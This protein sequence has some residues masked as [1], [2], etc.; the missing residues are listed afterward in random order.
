MVPILQQCR[1]I[2]I[3]PVFWTSFPLVVVLPPCMIIDSCEPYMIIITIIVVE[4]GVV[5]EVHMYMFESS[6]VLPCILT[7]VDVMMYIYIIMKWT[8]ASVLHLQ[9]CWERREPFFVI[10]TT[11]GENEVGFGA[12]GGQ[13]RFRVIWAL[14]DID[15]QKDRKQ[16]N[17]ILLT[18]A[19]TLADLCKK[20]RGGTKVVG[21]YT[22]PNSRHTGCQASYP[23][24]PTTT[25]TTT[26]TTPSPMIWSACS[27][28]TSVKIA[29]LALLLLEF[30]F[31]HIKDGQECDVCITGK[32][33]TKQSSTMLVLKPYFDH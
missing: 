22:L 13:I 16:F 27:L 33:S 17:G 30:I 26:T 18:L 19:L 12:M 7:P 10:N 11:Y 29:I 20:E 15:Q 2:S 21:L 24:P 14:R 1:S 9:H 23:P 8:T 31:Q 4:G 32:I 3:S 28:T 5:I 25:T 6:T